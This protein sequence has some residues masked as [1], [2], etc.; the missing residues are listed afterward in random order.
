MIHR[1]TA[2]SANV[3][4]LCRHL[5][6][7]GMRIGPTEETDAL[8]AMAEFPLSRPEQFQIIL[9]A[10]LCKSVKQQALFDLHFPDYWKQLMRAVDA[11][12]KEV[13]EEQTASPNSNAQPKPQAPSL[14]VLKS[15]LY[16]N[17]TEEEIELATY[18]PG[19]VISHKDFSA[20][21][22]SDLSELREVITQLARSLA[23]QFQ[24]RHERSKQQRQLDLRRTLRI[25]LRRGGE[26]LELAFRKKRIRRLSLVVLCDVSKS[27]DLYSR[28][29]VQFL[30]AFQNVYHRIET[31]VFS[32]SLFRVTDELRH[33]DFDNVLDDLAD[34]VKGWSGGTRIGHSLNTFLHDYGSRLLNDRTVIMILSDGWDTG[35]TELLESSMAQLHKKANRVIWLNPLAGKPGFSPST[36]CMEVAMPYIDTFASAHNIASL[37]GVLREVR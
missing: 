17:H 34:S 29:L 30:Y 23:T 7:Q 27:M 4:Q 37:R 11:K 33:S 9:R 14:Q 26:I 10:V 32:T 13:E 36:K 25:N 28:F 12:I 18:S 24:R 22:E 15:W 3:V 6:Q 2:L 1:Q 19:E 16:G 21:G 35:E 5:R 20:F 31:F 8:V